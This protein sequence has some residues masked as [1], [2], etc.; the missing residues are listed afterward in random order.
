MKIS[1]KVANRRGEHSASVQTGENERTVAIAPK[2]EGLGSSVNGGELLFLALA[3]CFCNDI[4]REAAKRGMEIRGVQVEVTGEFGGEGEPARE[5]RYCASVDAS[6]SREAVLDLMRHTD[7]VAEIH[8]TIRR[9]SAVI[10][11]DC[12]VREL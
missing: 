1:A 6:D 5:I 7:S 12:E 4:Y 11:S 9:G 3:T 10:F 2:Q 8:N